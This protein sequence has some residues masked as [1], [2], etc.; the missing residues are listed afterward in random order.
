MLIV[1][2]MD[3][4]QVPQ[5]PILGDRAAEQRL[6]TVSDEIS[7]LIKKVRSEPGPWQDKDATTN[8]V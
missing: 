3:D 2:L 8:P 6:Q 7:D 4:E 1:G 5:V